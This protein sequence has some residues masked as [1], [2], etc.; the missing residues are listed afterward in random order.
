MKEQYYLVNLY[1]GDV[2]AVFDSSDDLIAYLKRMDED[3]GLMG[4]AA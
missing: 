4:E 1:D 2:Q 3:G